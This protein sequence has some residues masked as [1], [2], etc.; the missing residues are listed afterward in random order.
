MRIAANL[1]ACSL[2]LASA[3]FLYAESTATRRLEAKIQAAELR[4]EKLETDISVL[5]AERAHLARPARIEPA[6][7]AMGMR[8]PATDDYIEFNRLLADGPAP[9]PQQAR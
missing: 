3:Y 7:K 6:A 5:R 1:I 4:R 2:T 8:L 9:S